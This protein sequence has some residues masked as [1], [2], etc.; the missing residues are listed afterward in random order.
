MRID[1]VLEKLNFISGFY[2]IEKQWNAFMS[3]KKRKLSA[4]EIKDKPNSQ[5][6]N[7][8]SF[9]R[10]HIWQFFQVKRLKV[11]QALKSLYLKRKLLEELR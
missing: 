11:L 5:Q 8:S 4:R 3:K 7:S 6:S 10:Y 1:G 9:L 2:L